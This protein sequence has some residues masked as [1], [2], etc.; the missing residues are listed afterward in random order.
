MEKYLIICNNQ[1]ML[2]KKNLIRILIN[3][4]IGLG[5]IIFWLKVVD[6]NEVFKEISQVQPLF[7]IPPIF[8]FLL[9]NILRAFRLKILLSDYKLKAL[10]VIFLNGI[11]Q[12]LNYFIP[13]RAGEIAK[14]IYLHTQYK[15]DLKKGVIWIFMELN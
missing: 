9:S 7:L 6:I 3:T 13:I 1:L 5:L 15:M 2:S 14:G 10:D 8:I 11:S 4:L 12:I